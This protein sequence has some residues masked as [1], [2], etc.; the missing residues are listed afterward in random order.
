MR[1]PAAA[2]WQAAQLPVP[3]LATLEQALE[4]TTA[5]LS[6]TGWASDLE[7]QARR[8]ARKRGL[9]SIAVIDHWVN[10]SSRFERHGAIVLPDEFWVADEDALAEARRCFPGRKVILQPNTYLDTLG[11]RRRPGGQ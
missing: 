2:L 5:L 11:A 9:R 10:Y 6:G 7:H 1:G 3:S 8:L 4:G